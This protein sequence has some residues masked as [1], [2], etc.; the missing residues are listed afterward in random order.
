MKTHSIATTKVVLLLFL[1]LFGLITAEDT[2]PV[3]LEKQS[4]IVSGRIEIYF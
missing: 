4:N 3:P 1:A 2:C